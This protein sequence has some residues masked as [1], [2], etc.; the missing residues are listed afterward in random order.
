MSKVTKKIVCI[1]LGA[2][3]ISL[4]LF[5]MYMLVVGAV[6]SYGYNNLKFSGFLALGIVP[7]ICLV[8]LIGYLFR[9]KRIYILPCIV[10]ACV[11]VLIF[12]MTRDKKFEPLPE[13]FDRYI[14]SRKL[15]YVYGGYVKP[16]NDKYVFKLGDKEYFVEEKSDKGKVIKVGNEYVLLIG[17][18]ADNMWLPSLSG[19]SSIDLMIYT[20]IGELGYVATDNFSN[21]Y[22][23]W[24]ELNNEPW[25]AIYISWCADRARILDDNNIFKFAYCPT[26]I[27]HYTLYDRF[28]TVESGYTPNAGDLFFQ[29]VTGE[30]GAGGDH[31]GIVI[32]YND[33]IVYSIEGNYGNAVKIVARPISK[34][35]GF[36]TAGGTEYGIK[37][38]KYELGL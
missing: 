18:T 31:T 17:L 1:V 25:C 38:K 23:K 6:M 20:G 4:F 34:L 22:G 33:G 19:D 36:A 7:I 29:T 21:K 24:Y 16:Y 3:G 8:F 27:E 11:F 14:D 28:R 12:S 9:K 2:S 35:Y 30:N 13:G 10:L 15:T 37:P 26:A 32:Y 5:I